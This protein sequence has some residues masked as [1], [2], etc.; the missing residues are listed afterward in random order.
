MPVEGSVLRASRKEII[1]E[2]RVIQ[3]SITEVESDALVVNLFEGVTVPGG[4]TGAVDRALDG[5]ITEL[6]SAGEIS[7]K[8]NKIALI[9][10]FGKIAPKRVLVVGL[11]KSED[12]DYIASAKAA[13]SA[14]KFLRDKGV[15]TITSIVHGAGIGGFEPVDAARSTVEGTIIALYRPDL[16]KTSEEDRP[17]VAAFT[18]VERDAE[19]VSEFEI[20]AREGKI[21]AEATN[22]ARTLGNEP[23]N[24]MTPAALADAARRVA[25]DFKLDIEVLER[26]QMEQLGMGAMLCVAQGS[27]QPPKLI[28]LSYKVKGKKPTLALVGKGLTFDSGGISIKPQENMADMKYD[29]AGGAAVIQAMRAIAELKPNVNVLGIVPAAENMPGGSAYKPGDVIKCSSGKTV[30]IV[31]TD[32]EG[33]MLLADAITLAIKKGASYIVDVATLTGSCAVALGQNVTG[34]MGNDEWLLDGVTDAAMLAGE[35]VWELP[36]VPEYMDMIKGDIA[37][38]K[39]CG[40]RW[41]GAITAGL[42]LKEFVEDRPWVHMDI[43]GTADSDKDEPYRAKGATGVGVRTLALLAMQLGE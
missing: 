34:I 25:E 14:A 28:T 38:V 9:H 22:E 3:G 27:V 5:K 24:I 42:F 32:A 17:D 33:R 21:L 41:G 1:V 6:I 36:L 4:A 7:G 29:M 12:F 37:D 43:A 15:R 10:T 35:Q 40:P 39:N 31:T 23:S 2:I 8:A 19:K 18:I 26:E 11:G 13:G 20:G 30:E 16:H